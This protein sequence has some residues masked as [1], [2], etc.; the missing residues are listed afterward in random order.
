MAITSE[1]G[2]SGTRTHRD[3]PS[4]PQARFICTQGPDQLRRSRRLPVTNLFKE[5]IEWFGTSR[6]TWPS[7]LATAAGL[8]DTVVATVDTRG[9]SAATAVPGGAASDGLLEEAEREQIDPV[10]TGRRGGGSLAELFA[11]SVSSQHLVHK[12]QVP[13]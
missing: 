9:D 5:R 12:A 8:R 1:H 11:G 7:L 13:L 6:Q 2:G 3:G 4:S 10:V